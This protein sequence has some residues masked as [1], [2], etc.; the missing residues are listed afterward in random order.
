LAWAA[1]AL[2]LL[3]FIIT[4]SPHLLSIT[5]DA[6]SR[7]PLSVDTSREIPFG[8]L[9]YS[10]VAFRLLHT[11]R[12][13]Q[14]G[15]LPRL[16]LG[17]YMNYVIFFPAFTAGPID[18]A[19]RFVSDLRSPLALSSEDWVAAATRLLVGLFKKI[20]LADMLAVI[21]FNDLL[22]QYVRRPGWMWL[23]LYAYAFRIFL[24]FSGYTDIAIA[25]GRLLGIRLP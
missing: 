17:E 16:G 10:Y 9:G 3:V 25:L 8:W 19:E 23:F 14:K 20:V 6:L 15:R 22:V 12:D 2:I 7:A 21:A 5:L 24:D 1:F 13:H 18:R 4:K 11:L